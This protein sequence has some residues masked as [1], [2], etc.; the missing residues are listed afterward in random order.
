[1][2]YS[3]TE[4]ELVDFDGLVRTANPPRAALHVHQHGL[5]AELAAVSHCSRDKTVLC[6]DNV[7]RY[8]AHDVMC[9]EYNLLESEVILLKPRT[10]FDTHGSKCPPSKSPSETVLEFRFRTPRL[11]ASAHERFFAAAVK[12]PQRPLEW[13]VLF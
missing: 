4:L 13:N 5:S 10:V 2:I 11:R 1:M 6:L 7:G 12:Q 8:A 9:E 3:P